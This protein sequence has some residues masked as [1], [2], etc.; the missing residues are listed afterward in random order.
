MNFKGFNHWAISRSQGYLWPSKGKNCI[1]EARTKKI[2]GAY[3]Q[4]KYR[5]SGSR[6]YC[7][8]KNGPYAPYDEKELVSK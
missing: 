1:S 3:A 5:K 4:K 6:P 8:E 7:Q 2:I